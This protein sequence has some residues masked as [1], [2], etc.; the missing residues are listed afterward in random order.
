M[1]PKERCRCGH[2]VFFRKLVLVTSTRQCRQFVPVAYDRIAEW[3]QY[4][5]IENMARHTH[6][7]NCC[8]SSTSPDSS[9]RI[10]GK[11]HP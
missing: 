6:I 9:H 11:V 1:T 3:S 2:R 4:S 10:P 8:H 5:P 7:H